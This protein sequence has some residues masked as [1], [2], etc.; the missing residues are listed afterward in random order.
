MASLTPLELSEPAMVMLIIAGAGGLKQVMIDSVVSKYTGNCSSALDAV[1]AL[2]GG[3]SSATILR[4]CVGSATVAD[5]DGRDPPAARDQ[6]GR[7]PRVD[8][9]GY[10]SGSLMHATRDDGGFWTR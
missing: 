2:P 10:R 4:I 5:Y 7:E 1:A 8:G 9:A 6:F 3:G